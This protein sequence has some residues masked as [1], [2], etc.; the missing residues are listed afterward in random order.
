MCL[1]NNNHFKAA[2]VRSHV[3]TWTQI[4]ASEEVVLGF[5]TVCQFHLFRTQVVFTFQ[6]KHLIVL[7]QNLSLTTS[8]NS[9]TQVLLGRL[10]A[11]QHVCLRLVVFPQKVENS[12][13]LL[14]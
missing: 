2:N 4:N 12:D 6:T 10:L 11:V 13:W 8:R 9:S 14:I 3:H 1:G 7:K 5:V